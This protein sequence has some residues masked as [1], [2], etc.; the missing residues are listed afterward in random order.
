M[1]QSVISLEA[2]RESAT[3]S[4]YQGYEIASWQSGQGDDKAQLLCIHGFPTASWDWHKLW[5]A[6][7]QRFSVHAIDML[8]FGYS[9]KPKNYQYSI[10]DQADLQ[11]HYL[12][13]RGIESAHLLAHDYGDSV[14]QELLGRF[15]DRQRTGQS[16][17]MIQSVIFLNGGLFPEMHRARLVQKLLLSPLG[18]LLSKFV[19][20]RNTDAGI[21]SVFGPQTQPSTDELSAFWELMEHN[22]GHRIGHL[23]IRYMLDRKEHRDRWLQALQQSTVPLR[24]IDGVLDPVSGGHMAD[25]YQQFVP[26]AD[27]VRLDVGHYP[28]VED[29]AGVLAACEKFW[30]KNQ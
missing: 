28:Q 11:E 7:T 27:V 13:E 9:A 15:L 17:L 8:G 4:T 10:H 18:P 23:L 19:S 26:G 14:A 22:G 12:Q 5:P 2:W 30:E 25:H 21:A 1:S 3:F 29:A 20:K 24:L 6:L 16:G